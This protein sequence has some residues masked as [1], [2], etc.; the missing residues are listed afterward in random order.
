MR[1]RCRSLVPH[2]CCVVRHGQRPLF[3]C[4]RSPSVPPVVST[5]DPQLWT[6]EGR[7]SDGSEGARGTRKFEFGKTGPSGVTPR[8]P[9]QWSG[10]GSP[11]GICLRG[12]PRSSSATT[13][14]PATWRAPGSIPVERAPE[15]GV[16]VKRTDQPKKRRRARKHGFRHRMSDLLAR[17]SSG[18]GGARAAI[19]SLYDRLG[20]GSAGSAI[21]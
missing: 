2:L 21:A 20:A 12:A 17:P 15:D 19:V 14:R 4:S 1:Q 18:P 13:R 8:G 11:R 10:P 16:S 5:V 7:G 9:V 3:R 6:S